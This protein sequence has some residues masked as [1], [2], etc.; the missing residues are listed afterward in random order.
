M[1]VKILKF[2][3]AD[4]GWKN[5]VV[6]NSVVMSYFVTWIRIREKEIL[7][8]LLSSLNLG[9]WTCDPACKFRIIDYTGTSDR[10]LHP[11][12]QCCGS[13]MVPSYSE[14]GS[15]SETR[16]SLEMTNSK[17]AYVK[18]CCSKV[19]KLLKIHL[20]ALYVPGT[21]CMLSTEKLHKFFKYLWKK[22]RS[23]PDSE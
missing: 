9:I 3:D 8:T 7:C 6:F 15:N 22:A 21:I 19:F 13:V 16:S 2:F 11:V 5:S 4:P 23:G 1:G 12:S 14:S 10:L 18:V 17:F 20:P